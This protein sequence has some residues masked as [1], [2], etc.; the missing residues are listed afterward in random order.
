MILDVFDWFSF[1][2]LMFKGHGYASQCFLDSDMNVEMFLNVVGS[3]RL[4][5]ILSRIIPNFSWKWFIF[6]LF[7]MIKGE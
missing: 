3:S 6:T 1:F 4:V 5:K 2:S 7:K